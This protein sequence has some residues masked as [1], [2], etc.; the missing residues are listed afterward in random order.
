VK[1]VFVTENAAVLGDYCVWSDVQ[2]N[3]PVIVFLYTYPS[4]STASNKGLRRTHFEG[5]NEPSVFQ[6]ED[7]SELPPMDDFRRTIFWNPSVKTD[8]EGRATVKFFNNSS[9]RELLL[10][11]EGITPNGTLVAK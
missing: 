11:I 9:A 5:F 1:S 4:Y 8:S 10:S 3:N 7:Y 6:M 2:A